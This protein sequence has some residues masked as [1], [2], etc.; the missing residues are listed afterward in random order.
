MIKK[1]K[2]ALSA[3]ATALIA[4]TGLAV[5]PQASADEM[6]DLK[7]RIARI[8]QQEAEKATR[9]GGNMVFFRG[10]YARNNSERFDY[11]TSIRGVN[12]NGPVDNDGW[13][14]GAGLDLNLS[15]DFFGLEDSIEVLGEIMFEY[16]E[17]AKTNSAANPLGTTIASAVDG[18]LA[19]APAA[20][21]VDGIVT[22]NGLTD[23]S[24]KVSQ[25]TLTASPKI[26]FMK[27]SR[28]RPWIIPVGLSI[29]V[30]SPPSDG[31]TVLEPGMHFGAGADVRVW[32]NVY[33]G[34]D[35]RYNLIF[36]SLDGV[37][38]EGFTTGAYAGFGF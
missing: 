2:L 34:A 20:G 38:L 30:I 35:I 21:G 18:Q 12:G 22:A 1:N 32:N 31:V 27:G 13:Y 24:V 33:V 23:G 28:F 16:K 11:L 29:H 26:K 8:E 17:F 5:A 4:V 7:A 15:D 9:D 19:P 10:G 6:A 37:D 36:G 3:A 25:F 14:V